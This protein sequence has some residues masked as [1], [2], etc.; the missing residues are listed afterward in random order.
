MKY[1]LVTIFLFFTLA[2]SAQIRRWFFET[3]R[4]PMVFYKSTPYLFDGQDTTS[5]HTIGASISLTKGDF[6]MVDWNGFPITTEWKYISIPFL[7]FEYNIA[8]SQGK[9]ELYKANDGAPALML[10]LGVTAGYGGSFIIFPIGIN[11]TLGLS[12]DFKDLYAKY[13]LGYDMWGLSIGVTGFLNMTNKN[14]SYYKTTPGLELRYIW[15]WD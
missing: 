14:D 2:S 11:G 12:S 8:N 15:N 3:N 10:S 6:D 7:G 9:A 13:G 4:S 5:I 1:I